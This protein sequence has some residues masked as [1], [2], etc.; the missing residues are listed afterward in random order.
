M[1][2][3]WSVCYQFGCQCTANKKTQGFYALRFRILQRIYVL[4]L[5]PFLA[6][7]YFHSNFLAFVQRLSSSTVNGTKMDEYVLSTFLLNET[8]TFLVIEP[9]NGTFYLL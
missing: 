3:R 6:L 7:S 2:S 4:C 9:L 5:R 1:E 8:E